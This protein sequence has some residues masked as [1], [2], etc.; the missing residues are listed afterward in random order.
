MGITPDSDEI[1][2]E[3]RRW[4]SRICDPHAT[5]EELQ[6]LDVWLLNAAHAQAF[7]RHMAP[8]ELETAQALKDAG[9]A[10][11]RDMYH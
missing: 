1:D 10:Y 6:A 3:A 5:V 11:E 9:L 7:G 8:I 4:V 2:A